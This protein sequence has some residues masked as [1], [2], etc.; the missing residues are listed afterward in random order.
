MRGYDLYY[1]YSYMLRYFVKKKVETS[2]IYDRV[3]EN[4]FKY[5]KSK[6]TIVHCM[7]QYTTCSYQLNINTIRTYFYHLFT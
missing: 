4:S 7:F 1:S 3:T 5:G 6:G 2:F